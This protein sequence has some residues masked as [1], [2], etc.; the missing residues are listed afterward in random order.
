MVAQR[1]GAFL[2]DALRAYD[3]KAIVVIGHRATKYALVYWSSGQPLEEIVGTPWE[4]R[5][6]P[7]WRYTF[8]ASALP[9]EPSIS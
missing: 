8:E 2:R 7:I 9:G 3:S 5:D 1:V 6:V 4:W